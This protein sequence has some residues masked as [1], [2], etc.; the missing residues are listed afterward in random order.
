MVVVVE[1]R[2]GSVLEVGDIYVKLGT[3]SASSPPESAVSISSSR[4]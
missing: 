2:G 3:S 4:V 1:V